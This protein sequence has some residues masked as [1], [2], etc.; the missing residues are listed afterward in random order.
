M[1]AVSDFIPLL[2]ILGTLTLLPT[3]WGTA[4]QPH[5]GADGTEVQTTPV[6]QL[7]AP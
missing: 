5:I 1:S 4:V 2:P 6:A 3:N 7:E